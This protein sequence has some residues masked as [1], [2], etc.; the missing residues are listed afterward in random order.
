MKIYDEVT[1]DMNPESSTYGEHLSEESHD[2]SGPMALCGKRTHKYKIS[3]YNRGNPGTQ[4]FA[5]KTKD[6]DILDRLHMV[7]KI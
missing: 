3:K 5:R 2:Y 7:L 6:I 4:A 1:I